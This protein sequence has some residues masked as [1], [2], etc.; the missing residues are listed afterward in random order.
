MSYAMHKR[1]HEKGIHVLRCPNKDTQHLA[2]CKGCLLALEMY[3]NK[4]R[5]EE[6]CDAHE[7]TNRQLMML[8]LYG[9]TVV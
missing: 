2:D 6:E 7:K 5:Y 3:W 8:E 9:K 4:E 1:F